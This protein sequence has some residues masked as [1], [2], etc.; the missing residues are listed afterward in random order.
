MVVVEWRSLQA[1]QRVV[2]GVLLEVGGTD[3]FIHDLLLL[4]NARNLYVSP[5]LEVRLKL[6]E[7]I[8][9]PSR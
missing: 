7:P 1:N 4:H 8:V 3:F 5:P 6:L 2:P 9:A